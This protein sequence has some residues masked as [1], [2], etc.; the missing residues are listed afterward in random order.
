MAKNAYS[1]TEVTRAWNFTH[2][3]SK[4]ALWGK[5]VPFWGQHDGRQHFGVVK[6]PHKPSKM[7]LYKHVR[8]SANGLKTNDVIEDWR[9]W[10]AVARRPSGV[11]YL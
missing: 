4:H 2:D 3:G 8:A 9:H 11:Y 1:P 6:I 7:A 5:E 10:L